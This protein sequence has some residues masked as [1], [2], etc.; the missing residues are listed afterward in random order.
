MAHSKE[1]Y[2]K[3]MNYYIKL[4]VGVLIACMAGKQY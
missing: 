3:N 1:A 2:V 4:K